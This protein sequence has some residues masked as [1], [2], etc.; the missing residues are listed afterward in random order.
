MTAGERHHR[1]RHSNEI[2][3][4]ARVMRDAGMSYAAIAAELGVS[5]NTVRDWV[6]YR[7]RSHA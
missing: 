7:T 1:A 4:R 5:W 2:V 3:E 6:A